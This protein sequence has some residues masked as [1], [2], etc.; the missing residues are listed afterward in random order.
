MSI[1][2]ERLNNTFVEKIS[3]ILHNDI[4]DKDVKFVTITEVRITNDLSFA[5]V[6]FTSNEENRRQVTEAL[7]KASGFIRSRLCE[8]VQLRK[9]PEIHFVYDESVE[10]GQR[11]DDIIERINHEK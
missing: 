2:M 8:K 11:I 10:Y 5:K 6:Y 4:K 7:N 3:E 9:M 1:K